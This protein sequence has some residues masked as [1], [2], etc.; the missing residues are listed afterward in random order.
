[1]ILHLTLIS[2]PWKYQQI[3]VVTPLEFHSIDT[4]LTYQ[5]NLTNSLQKNKN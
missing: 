5:Q 1:M 4:F 2:H 3:Q